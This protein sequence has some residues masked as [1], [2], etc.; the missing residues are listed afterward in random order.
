MPP[1]DSGPMT[2]SRRFPMRDATPDDLAAI[3]ALHESVGWGV[4]EWAL[5]TV[6]GQPFARAS[7][8]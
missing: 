7:L 1:I 3:G 2:V 5:R 8:R 6:I 4:N